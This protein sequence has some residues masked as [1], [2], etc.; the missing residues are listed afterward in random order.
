M[1]LHKM[2]PKGSQLSKAFWVATGFISNWLGGHGRV[3]V[4]ADKLLKMDGKVRSQI[5]DTYAVLYEYRIRYALES[6]TKTEARFKCKE[7][8]CRRKTSE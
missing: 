8:P 4:P 3:I 2:L 7:L 1:F 6:I 5:T